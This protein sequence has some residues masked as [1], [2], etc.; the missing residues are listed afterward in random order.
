MIN[1]EN[2]ITVAGRLLDNRIVL[3]HEYKGVTYYSGVLLVERAS[4]NMDKLRVMIPERLLMASNV[5]L[6]RPLEITG[7][8]RVYNAHDDLVRYSATVYARDMM[9]VESAGTLNDVQLTGVICKPPIFRKTPFGREIND[10]TLAVERGHGKTDYLPCIA[11]GYKARE[12]AG[13]GVGD[14]IS[15]SG[16]MQSRDYHKAVESGECLTRTAYEIS[17]FSLEL[18]E[19]AEATRREA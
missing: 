5:A 15:L 9:A 19:S 8:V 1:F 4:G 10:F 12:V 11:W 7:Q 17:A 6:D 16:R 14:Q 2:K 13:F 18:L 3:D